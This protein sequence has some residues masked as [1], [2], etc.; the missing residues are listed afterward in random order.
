MSRKGKSNANAAGTLDE[1][2]LPSYNSIGKADVEEV[3]KPKKIHKKGW[4]NW[5]NSDLY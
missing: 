3:V 5:K 4:K 2:E 1:L